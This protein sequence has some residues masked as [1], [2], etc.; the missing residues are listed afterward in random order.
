M[1]KRKFLNW[2]F[3]ADSLGHYPGGR[4]LIQARLP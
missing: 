2:F 4:D 3:F 1:F